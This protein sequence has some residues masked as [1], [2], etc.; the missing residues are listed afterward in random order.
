ML[1]LSKREDYAIMILTY[2]ST[3]Q[4]LGTSA[5]Q[6]AEH[7]RISTSFTATILKDLTKSE[8]LKSER[9]SG[10][11]YSLNILPSELTIFHVLE[12][13][14]GKYAL[15]SCVLE[16]SSCDVMENCSIQKP[17]RLLNDKIVNTL[18]TLT[19]A[20]LQEMATL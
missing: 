20:S 13:I 2:L 11:G 15:T 5:R 14:S 18:N 16:D 8:I 17:I 3:R 9:G 7:H 6:V 10:G 1:R 4:G 19:I 12:G